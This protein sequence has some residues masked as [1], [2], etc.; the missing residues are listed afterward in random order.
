MKNFTFLLFLFLS[1]NSY[2][3]HKITV[4]E[5]KNTNLKAVLCNVDT[6]YFKSNRSVSA[7][8]YKIS[9][10][11][12]SAHIPETDESSNKFLIAVTN[13]D[14]EPDQSLYSVGDFYDPKILKFEALENDTFRLIIEYGIAGHRKKVSYNIGLNHIVA[15]K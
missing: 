4:S 10:P 14:E 6:V 9:N 8:L 2:A 11:A 15:D 7:I 5:L 1:I 3:Q 12:G 13:G